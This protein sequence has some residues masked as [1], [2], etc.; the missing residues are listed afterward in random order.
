MWS[1]E[2]LQDLVQTKVHG[3]T[4][5][6]QCKLEKLGKLVKHEL[7]DLCGGDDSLMLLNAYNPSGLTEPTRRTEW[8]T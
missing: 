3:E 8:S 5:K 4:E 6:F 2:L 7:A 1:L